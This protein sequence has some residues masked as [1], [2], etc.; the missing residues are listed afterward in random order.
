MFTKVLI[1]NRGEIALRVARTLREMGVGVVSVYSDPD[2]EAPHLELSDQVYHLKGES[3]R[4]TYLRQDLLL[5]IARQSGAQAVHPGYGFLSEN[6]EFARACREQG[7]V[8]IGPPPDVIQG[9][10]DKMEAKAAMLAADV[11]V[12]PSWTPPAELSGADLTRA[13]S[14]AARE[15]GYPILIKAAAGGGGK[16][17]RRVDD[18][19]ELEEAVGAARREAASAFG[20][21][22]VFLEKY[23]DRPRHV[24]VQLFGDSHGNVVHLFERECSIQRR[25]QKIVEESPSPALTP[26]LRRAM[27]EAAC[28]AARALGY[29]NAGTAEFLVDAQGGFYFL[30]VNARLQV[31]HPVT[32]TLVGLDLVRLQLEVAAGGRLPFTQEELSPRGHCLE[33]RLYAE[34]PE[35]GFLPSIGTL[36]AFEVPAWPG[37][38]LDT[39]VRQGSTISTH[40][41]PMLAKLIAWGADRRESIQRMRA[42][43][44]QVVVLGVTTNLEFLRNLLAHPDFV[45]GRTHTHFLQDHKIVT[46]GA[47]PD[48]AFVAA[49]LLAAGSRPSAALASPWE[50]GPW[51]NG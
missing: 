12:V 28:R 9:L 50:S 27:G 15:L 48:E 40:Y 23:F 11:P 20:D 47:V 19:T 32:E 46:G 38:R 6:P 42:W 17:M 37:T 41:D 49:A 51:R 45:A 26:E 13:R 3:A 44:E 35:R 16:G 7:L 34:D 14:Q 33:V 5:E 4:E 31:E 10:G 24:E 8:F 29:Q 22:R 1:A 36:E 30:E 25:Y 21:D 43:L 39:G 2:R 18:P